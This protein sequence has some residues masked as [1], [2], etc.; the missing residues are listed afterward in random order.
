MAFVQ[1]PDRPE[2]FQKLI[3]GGED[4]GILAADQHVPVV[5]LVAVM[6]AQEE[7]IAVAAAQDVGSPVCYEI[8][9]VEP[10]HEVP[11]L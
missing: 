7:V 3:Q 1:G 9:V 2:V 11:G 6:V 5:V 10:S 8:L 4:S